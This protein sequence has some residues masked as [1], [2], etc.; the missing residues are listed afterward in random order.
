ME[1]DRY[2]CRKCACRGTP[3]C[4]ECAEVL[5]PNGRRMRPKYYALMGKMA[6][7]FCTLELK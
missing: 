6:E 1:A 5:F 2:E 4:G 7:R 3:I